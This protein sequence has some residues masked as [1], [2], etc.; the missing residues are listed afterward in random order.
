ML[1]FCLRKKCFPQSLHF[2]SQRNP[3]VP[4]SERAGQE[5]GS[6]EEGPIGEDREKLQGHWRWGALR[7]TGRG[8][9]LG[10][11]AQPMAFARAS[12]HG[13]AREAERGDNTQPSCRKVSCSGVEMAV[14]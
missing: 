11:S 14:W 2:F 10:L 6:G 13:W 1:S 4:M 9:T 5:K 7:Q 8:G 12:Q 3:R